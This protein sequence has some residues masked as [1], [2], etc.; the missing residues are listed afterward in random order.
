MLAKCSKRTGKQ[1]DQAPA[2]ARVVPSSASTAPGST[3]ALDTATPTGGMGV[4]WTAEFGGT[5]YLWW[6]CP[7]FLQARIDTRGL[8]GEEHSE[9]ETQL[10]VFHE[11]TS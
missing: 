1:G 3:G 5:N 4:G 9:K 11:F 8:C 7:I 10:Q 2:S 6:W